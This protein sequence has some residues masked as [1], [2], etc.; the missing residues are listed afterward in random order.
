MDTKSKVLL[1]EIRSGE[2]KCVLV[3]RFRYQTTWVKKKTMVWVEKKYQ[4]FTGLVR[5]PRKEQF[6]KKYITQE[7]QLEK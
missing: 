3:P 6:H 1:G 2:K 7:K 5:F 4:C